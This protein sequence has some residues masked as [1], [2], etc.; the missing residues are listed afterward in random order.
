LAWTAQKT[1]FL[2]CCLIDALGTCLFAKPLL[3]DGCG[4]FAYLA[5][6]AQQ[7][8]CMSQFCDMMA[9]R[10]NGATKKEQPLLCDGV[11]NTF[12]QQQINMQQ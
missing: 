4:I 2:C 5:V 8:V 9:E 11:G 7:Q 12:L 10:W 1:P 3:S 6:M